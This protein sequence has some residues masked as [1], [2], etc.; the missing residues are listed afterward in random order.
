MTKQ[1]GN[2]NCNCK[3]PLQPLKLFNLSGL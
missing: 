1:K 3:V 2:Y